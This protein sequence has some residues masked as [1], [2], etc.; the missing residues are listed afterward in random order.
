MGHGQDMIINNIN[1]RQAVD[2]IRLVDQYTAELPP[3]SFL[4]GYGLLN[5]EFLSFLSLVEEGDLKSF[6]VFSLSIDAGAADFI[7]YFSDT[8]VSK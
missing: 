3:Q 7:K 4:S 5:R 8:Y 2:C 1:K 6:N